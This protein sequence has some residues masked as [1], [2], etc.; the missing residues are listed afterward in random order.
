MIT[1]CQACADAAMMGVTETPVDDETAT[2][3]A[4]GIEARNR[5]VICAV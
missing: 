1:G 4:I 5:P 2:A 3:A